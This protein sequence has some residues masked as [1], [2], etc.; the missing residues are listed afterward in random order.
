MRNITDPARDARILALHKT[1]MRPTEIAKLVGMHPA[2]MVHK[3]R[4]LGVNIPKRI[5]ADRSVTPYV[6]PYNPPPRNPNWNTGTWTAE[7]DAELKRLWMMGCSASVIAANGINRSKNAIIGRV[8]RLNLPPRTTVTRKAVA[9]GASGRHKV[10]SS[11]QRG[12]RGEPPSLPAL[13]PRKA[14]PVPVEPYTGPAITLLKAGP[15]ECRFPVTE[16]VS[17]YD[18]FFCGG[19]VRD[20]LSFCPDHA[21]RAFVKGS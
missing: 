16:W 10:S 11:W 17:P 6:R 1:G 12:Y 2:G 15:G 5:W 21:L 3:L 13:K 20:G 18:P 19:P 8:A 4:K 14:K 7:E 9:G